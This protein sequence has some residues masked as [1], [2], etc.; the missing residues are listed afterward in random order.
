MSSHR[1]AVFGHPVAHSLSP[2]I[3]AAFAQQGGIT[4]EYTAIDTAPHDFVAALDR[5]AGEGGAGANVTLPLKEAAFAS[6][7]QASDLS[8]IHI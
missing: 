6:C 2:R 7:A 8:L 5:F 4:L 1:Y 3:H